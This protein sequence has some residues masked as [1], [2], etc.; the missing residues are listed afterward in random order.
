VRIDG[1][2]IILTRERRPFT[3]RATIAAAGIDPMTQQIVVVKLGYLFPDLHDHAPRT[4]MA[5][6]AGATD[7]RLTEL[8]Y[9]RVVRPIFPLDPDYAWDVT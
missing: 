9:Q 8:P 2:R 5:L 4:I 3:D 1:V 6:S 7:L